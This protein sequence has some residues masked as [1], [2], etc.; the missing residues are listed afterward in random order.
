M[1]GVYLVD[2]DA[3]YNAAIPTRTID[4]DD[5]DDDDYVSAPLSGYQGARARGF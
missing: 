4:D 5:D 2:I 3:I 1:T